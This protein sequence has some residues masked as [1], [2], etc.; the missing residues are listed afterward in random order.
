[1]VWGFVTRALVRYGLPIAGGIVGGLFL[2]SWLQQNFMPLMAMMLMFMMVLMVM[3]MLMTMRE[4]MR[5]Y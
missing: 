4:A 1:M 2:A 3:N 5:P